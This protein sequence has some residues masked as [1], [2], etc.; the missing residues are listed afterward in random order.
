MKYSGDSEHDF[1]ASHLL[2]SEDSLVTGFAY[3]DPTAIT[4]IK[5]PG[6][7]EYKFAIH[8]TSGTSGTSF[9]IVF[10]IKRYS[11]QLPVGRF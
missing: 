7:S 9:S 5:Y 2:N 10:K 4:N 6:D 3:P 8:A 1:V 11:L